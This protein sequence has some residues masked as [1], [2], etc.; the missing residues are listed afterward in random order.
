MGE[1]LA[2]T[3]W[4]WVGTVAALAVW[5]GFFDPV[6]GM[7]DAIVPGGQRLIGGMVA[8]AVFC[9]LYFRSHW[10]AT[11][12]V[13]REHGPESHH[14]ARRLEDAAADLERSAHVIGDNLT[15]VGDART[16][17]AQ[18]YLDGAKAHAT[19][20][21]DVTTRLRGIAARLTRPHHVD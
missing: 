9:G 6:I 13:L 7:I 17:A 12:T 2:G 1:K 3:G 19:K 16:P 15:E 14:V 11:L 21:A 8:F 20:L 5:L 18:L 10:A 4:L